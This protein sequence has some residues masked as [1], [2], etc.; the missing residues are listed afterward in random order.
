LAVAVA[1]VNGIDIAYRLH[2]E[3]EPILL[4]CGTGQRADSWSVLGM[5]DEPVKSGYQVITFDNRGMAPSACPDG[6]Y[7]VEVMADD[8]I[9][10][11]EHLGLSA[12]R[13][14]GISL[15]GFITFEVA[16]RRPDLV[17]GAV[18]IAGLVGGSRYVRSLTQAR[19]EAIRDGHRMPATLDSLLSL[20]VTF[21]PATVQND[22]VIGFVTSMMGS[23]DREWSGPGRRGQYEADTDWILRPVSWQE[24]ALA[25]TTVPVLVM[26][27]EYDPFF[28][29]SLLQWAAERLPAGR[30]VEIA[31]CGHAGLEDVAAHQEAAMKFFASL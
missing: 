1:Q 4:V 5:I 6:P 20:P 2:G 15:G 25:E 11:I 24:Q 14:A 28:P 17:R 16:R 13:M 18:C 21:A 22:D 29:P 3:G 31:G 10:L 23:V 7:S 30:Y 19:V 12:V 27:H 26:A 9:A 8:A